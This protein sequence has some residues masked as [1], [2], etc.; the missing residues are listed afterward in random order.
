MG[1][2]T[3]RFFRVATFGESHGPALGVVVDGLPAGLPLSEA[4][5]QKDLD[6]RRPGQSPFVSARQEPDRCEILSGLSEGLTNGAPLALLIRN[7]DARGGD[8]RTL[9]DRFRPGHADWPFFVKYGLKPQP[10]GGRASGRETAARVAA[11][12]V[13]RALLR[14][15]GVEV[16]AAAAAVGPIQAQARDWAFAEADPLRYLDPARA[17]EV[18]ALVQ[19]AAREGDSVGAVVE[20]RAEGLP[21]GWGDPVFDKLEALLGGAF[22]SIGAVRAVEFGD[23]LELA[24]AFGSQAND[25]LGP[26]GPLSDRHGGVLGGL[27][28]G[29]PLTARLFVKPTPSIAK[30]QK[31]VDLD[32][33]PT[34]IAVGGRHDPCLA[35]RL[36][37]VAEAMALMVLADCRLAPP[38]KFQPQAGGRE[39]GDK[40]SGEIGKEIC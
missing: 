30:P 4:D 18:A 28:T 16:R 33:R 37:P 14:P 3:G 9:A 39:A 1:S 13:A 38:G 15:L 12:A 29:R 17:A 26:E 20:L 21:P 35:P 32:G 27:S 36:A 6:R 31:T 8:Y 10:G 40:L 23:G 7:Q 19:K 34:D 24:A 11:G 5:V 25:P 2:M 22:F